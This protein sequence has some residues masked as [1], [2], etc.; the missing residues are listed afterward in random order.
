MNSLPEMSITREY[1]PV[2]PSDKAEVISKTL[3]APPF[4][5][6][7]LPSSVTATG[8]TLPSWWP[9]LATM[10]AG[11]GR[12]PQPDRP[13][14]AAQDH[15]PVRRDSYR[16]RPA[17]M[18]AQHT[19]AGVASPNCLARSA[20]ARS[21]G[22]PDVSDGCC[23]RGG[24]SI[25]FFLRS[26][27]DRYPLPATLRPNGQYVLAPSAL[28]GSLPRRDPAGRI[29]ASGESA[30]GTGSGKGSWVAAARR[31]T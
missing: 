19:V 28:P 5:T 2:P 10:V 17:I 4:A 25:P 3:S 1:V 11:V 30:A 6:A 22:I 9:K 12:V 20:A 16:P 15:L 21:S 8:A 27:H 14:L 26:R 29:L 13:I 7:I 23:H 18:V 24:G 31:T